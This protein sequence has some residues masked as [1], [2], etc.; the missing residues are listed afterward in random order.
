MSRYIYV[1]KLI[2]DGWKLRREKHGLT[3]ISFETMELDCVP[4]ADVRENVR[5]E[6]IEWQKCT[7]FYTQ[8]LYKCS[9]CNESYLKELVYFSDNL[10]YHFCPNCGA[11]MRK[12]EKDE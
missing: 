7:P 8:D 6:W 2:K 12:G 9:K 3:T 4:T 5:G 10:Q 11:N 1:D